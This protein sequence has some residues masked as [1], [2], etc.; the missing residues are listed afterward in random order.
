[1]APHSMQAKVEE[2]KKR[3]G[4]VM[5]GGG[6]DKQEKQRQAGKLTAR[7]RIDA[8]TRHSRNQTGYPAMMPVWALNS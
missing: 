5:L 2:L 4:A 8:L 1:M 3:R 7:E 6:P